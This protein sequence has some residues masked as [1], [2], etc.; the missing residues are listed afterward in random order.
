MNPGLL[1]LCVLLLLSFLTVIWIDYSP[2]VIAYYHTL[3]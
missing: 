3:L 2:V 1:Y